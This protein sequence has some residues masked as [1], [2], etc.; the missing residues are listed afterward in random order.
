MRVCVTVVW[1]WG[2]EGVCDRC[3]EVK[4]ESVCDR[5]VEVGG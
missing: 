3:V 1:R 4:G 5:C 2:D